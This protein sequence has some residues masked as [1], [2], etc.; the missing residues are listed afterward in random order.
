MVK[1]F[2]FARIPKICF[3][4]GIIA[5]LPGIARLYGNKIILVTG[6]NSFVQSR[7][8]EKLFHDFE[9]AGIG[10]AVFQKATIF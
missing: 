7:H 5:E 4:N 9:K 2:Q 1:P 8:A 6:K 3:K 10:S